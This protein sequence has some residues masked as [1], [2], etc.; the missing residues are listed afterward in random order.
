METSFDET[1]AGSWTKPLTDGARADLAAFSELMCAKLFATLS[2]ACRAVDPNHLNLG[3]RYHTVPPAWAAKG[4]SRF[5]VFSMN[6]YR[7]RVPA[8]ELARIAKMLSRPVLVG[9]WHFGAHD[10]G[11]PAS[12]IG[13]VKDQAARGAAFRLYTEDAAA[14]PECI[15]VH[16]FTLY[17]QSALGRFDG[18]CYNIGFLDVCNNPYEDLATMARLAHERLYGIAAGEVPPT[19]EVPEYLPKLFL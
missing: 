5:D 16:Y 11:L 18:E 19:D 15:G 1:A 7:E 8:E 10:V 14:K 12:G 6:C 2:D 17:D 9:E 3:A 13:R 4:M